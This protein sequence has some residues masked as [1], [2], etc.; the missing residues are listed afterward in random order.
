MKNFLLCLL[1]FLFQISYAQKK[2]HLDYALEFETSNFLEDESEKRIINYLVDSKN[3]AILMTLSED[4][5]FNYNIYLIDREK[6]RIFSK[7]KKLDFQKAESLNNSCESVY[8]YKCHFGFNEMV[9]NYKFL[10]LNDTV[11]N[12]ISYFHYKSINIKQKKKKKFFD[13]HY[14]VDKNSPDFLPFLF[15][16]T[17][18]EVWKKVKNIPNGMPFLIFY[19]NRKGEVTYKMQLKQYVTINKLMTIPEDCELK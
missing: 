7:V 2:Y 12:G 8:V 17:A 16:N 4:D 5:S 11:M 13:V 1:I 3:N 19:K 18:Y 15:N 10:N 14:I 6:L 9:E